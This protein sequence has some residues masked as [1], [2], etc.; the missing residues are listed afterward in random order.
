MRILAM[1]IFGTIS[2]GPVVVQ[3]YAPGYPFCLRSRGTYECSYTTLAQCNASASGR[4]AQCFPNP[5]LAKAQ[6]PAGNRW[7]RRGY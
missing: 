7:Q 6:E 5:Y 1:A 4:A 3:T 2:I